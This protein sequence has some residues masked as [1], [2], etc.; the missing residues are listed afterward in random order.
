MR[1]QL[2]LPPFALLSLICLFPDL[3][4]AIRWYFLRY[5]TPPGQ[6]FLSLRGNMHVPRLP[7]GGIYYLWPGLQATDS[8]GVYQNVLD[9]TSGTWQFLN[10]WCCSNPTIP[11]GVGFNATEGQSLSFVNTR[12]RRGWT[13][14]LRGPE[15]DQFAFDRFPLLSNKTFNQALFAIELHDEN[16]DFGPLEFSNIVIISSGPSAEWCNDS[17]E[18][19][20]HN[21]RYEIRG[22]DS[23]MLN[24]NVVACTIE[25]IGLLGPS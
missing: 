18:N 5:W 13:S 2:P 17:P 24:D 20:S 3:A 6:E 7:R 19:Y 16:W 4:F 25:Y 14:T 11:W 1:P 15:K 10:I 12:R 9:G 8:S 23:I 21:A 22:V